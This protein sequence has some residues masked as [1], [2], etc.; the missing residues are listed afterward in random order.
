MRA[1]GIPVQREGERKQEK[2]ERG[3]E[4]GRDLIRYSVLNSL[5]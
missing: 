4:K 2:G 3:E 5:K 1:R